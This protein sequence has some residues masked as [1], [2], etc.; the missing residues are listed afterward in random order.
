[1]HFVVIMDPPETVLV[2]KDTSFA[3]M[4]ESQSRG[5]RVDHCLVRDLFLVGGR[6][7][8]RVRQARMQQVAEQPIALGDAEDV[9]LHDVDAIFVRKDPPFDSGYLWCTVMLDRVKHD[10]FV[11]NDPEGLRK[12]NEKLYTC[13]FPE[14]MPRTLVSSDK[15]RIKRFVV[16]VGGRA[17][18]KPLDGA[19]GEGVMTLSTG[20]FNVNAIIELT[21]HHG[22]RLAMA[23]EFLPAVHEGDKRILLLEGDPLG[24]L[25]RVPQHGEI[26]SNLHVGG[27]AVQTGVNEAERR[28]IATLKPRL[29]QDGLYFV[30]IDVIGGKLTEVNVTSPTG[31]QQMSRMDGVDYCARVIDWVEARVRR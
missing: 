23:Q 22:E 4:F 1:M 16:E 17:V 6:L 11:M 31:I 26:R 13:H 30:G 12:A 19:G 14:L 10:T 27:A 2:D 9:C 28:I 25:L 20:D 5:H 24:A 18:L 8:A 29:K 15:D 3:L 7:F 21:T